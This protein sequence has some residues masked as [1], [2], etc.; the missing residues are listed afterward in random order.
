M[1]DVMG[2]DRRHMARLMVAV[3]L[4]FGVVSGGAAISFAKPSH[5]DLV[6]AEA[7]LNTLNRQ[8]SALVEQYDQA[9][10]KLQQTESA[11]TQARADVAGA[12]ADLAQAQA[13]LS[14]QARSAYES[15]GTAISAL[16][17]A[18]TFADLSDRVQFLQQL[19]QQDNDAAT[20]AQVARES[21]RRATTRLNT[22][23]KQ[24]Q[25][26]VA[27]LNAKKNQIESGIAKTQSLV[28]TIKKSLDR[29]AAQ[30][31][32]NGSGGGGG[33][34]PTGGSGGGSYPP[35]QGAAAA[36]QAAHEALGTPY[37]WGGSSLSGFDC[38]GLTMWSWAHGGVYLPHSAA[39]QYAVTRHVFTSDLQPGDLLFFYSPIS[40]VAMYIG[41]GMEIAA[42][43]TG[44]VV[45]VYPVDWGNFVGAGRP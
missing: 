27:Q 23:L 34:P 5:A 44:T 40:H 12:Q 38:S 22:I 7:K 26:L 8:M 11:L 2:K 33:S 41:G 37:R 4:I 30:R 42:S 28:S 25:A 6:A 14:S 24:R 17:G 13:T 35:A 45:S 9:Q 3:A 1:R 20:K 19:A 10:A 21:S 16:L 43:H 39:M 15:Q 18:S 31:V 36:V 29:Q 32:L